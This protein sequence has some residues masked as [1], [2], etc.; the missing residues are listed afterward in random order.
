MLNPENN[1]DRPD[2]QITSL[3]E[4]AAPLSR[5]DLLWQLRYKV[6]RVTKRR[7]NYLHNLISHTTGASSLDDESDRISSGQRLLAGQLVRVRSKE[8][9]QST[10]DNWNNLKGCG[11]MEEM[12]QYCNTRQRVLKPVQR[13]VDERDQQVKRARGIV[14][15]QGVHCE[16]TVDYGK[17]DRNCYFFWREEWL[18]KVDSR[19]A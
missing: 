4:M 11:F 5:I 18:E 7:L 9:I 3:N 2:C 19:T 15:L 10:L 16:G 6:K 1:T 12:W 17:C 8:E 13:F 14:F